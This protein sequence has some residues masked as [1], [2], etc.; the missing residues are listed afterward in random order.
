MGLFDIVRRAITGAATEAVENSVDVGVQARQIVREKM[1]QVR[2]ANAAL[3]EAKT[4][5]E[6]I[7]NELSDAEAEVTKWTNAASNSAK[8][9]NKDLAREC[10]EAKNKANNKVINLKSRLSQVDPQIK[11]LQDKIDKT[12]DQISELNTEADMMDARSKISAA[13]TKTTQVLQGMSNNDLDNDFDN[14]RDRVDREEARA[15]VITDDASRTSGDNLEERVNALN[16]QESLDNE[17][18]QLMQSSK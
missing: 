7:A 17:L 8:S 5:R 16:K 15:K 3:I 6:L 10:L 9:G 11:V 2:E 13:Q 14:L 1:E 18:E 4:T 12:N